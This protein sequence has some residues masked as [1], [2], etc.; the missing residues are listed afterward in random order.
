MADLLQTAQTWLAGQFKQHASQT[1][2]YRR[3]AAE[4]S[5]QATPGRTTA[6]QTDVEGL[7]VE[8]LVNDFLIQA[9]D[10]DLGAGPTEPQLGD[11]IVFAG[12][13]YSVRPHGGELWRH[14][15]SYGQVLRIHTK[16]IARE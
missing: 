5:V 2:T 8:T 4:I 10:L 7:T 15:D 13:T 6:E 14:S 1:V 12:D 9:T 16:R 11:E 3:G